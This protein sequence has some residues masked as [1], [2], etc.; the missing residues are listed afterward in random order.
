MKLVTL[1]VHALSGNRVNRVIDLFKKL[2]PHVIFLQEISEPILKQ[3][4]LG[5]KYKYYWAKA[6]FLGNGLLSAYDICDSYSIILN[7]GI[8]CENRSAIRATINT[9]L[10]GKLKFIGTHLDHLHEHNRLLQMKLL[11]AHFQNVDFIMGD[12]NS[13]HVSD[14]SQPEINIINA[15]RDI[16]HIEHVKGDVMEYI[17]SHG[18]KINPYVHWTSRFETRI[19]FI[20]YKTCSNWTTKETVINTIKDHYSDHCLVMA[21]VSK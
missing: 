7:N 18:Y 9:P 8:L 14:Y 11:S 5:L 13:I 2:T 20:M 10:Y 15:H 3:V 1:N 4:A 17:K 6:D 21:N 12:F 16:G 19:D